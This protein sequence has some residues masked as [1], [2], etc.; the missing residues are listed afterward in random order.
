MKYRLLIALLLIVGACVVFMSMDRK[1][2]KLNGTKWQYV[3]KMFVADA[4][5]ETTTYTLEF[6]TDKDVVKTR[7][8]FMPPHPAMYMDANGEVPTVPG[9][10]SSSTKKGTYRVKRNV[11]SVTLEDGFTEM[12]D[13]KDGNLVSWRKSLDGENMTF[14]PFQE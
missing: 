1:K 5:T 9:W 7:R 4:G 13:Y 3:E 12:Y 10:E 11:V 8:T 2:L 6:T 14:S